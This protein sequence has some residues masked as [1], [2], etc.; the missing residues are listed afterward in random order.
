LAPGAMQTVPAAA[1]RFLRS[2]QRLAYHAS[3]QQTEIRRASNTGV[4]TAMG[5]KADEGLA[6]VLLAELSESSY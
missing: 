2:K 3:W 4:P 6:R 5:A 1:S